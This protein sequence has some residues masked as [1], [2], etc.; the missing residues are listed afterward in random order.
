M[1]E[2]NHYTTYNNIVEKGYDSEFETSYDYNDEKQNFLY[3]HIHNDQFSK[4]FSYDQ[5]FQAD[6]SF[7]ASRTSQ[8][9]NFK[10]ISQKLKRLNEHSYDQQHFTRFTEEWQNEKYS[11][12]ILSTTLTSTASQEENSPDVDTLANI[13]YN[14]TNILHNIKS[15]LSPG[16][17]EVQKNSTDVFIDM[18]TLVILIVLLKR[19]LQFDIFGSEKDKEFLVKDT[20]S[21]RQSRYYRT[22]RETLKSECKVELNNSLELLN[23]PK[24]SQ[25]AVSSNNLSRKNDSSCDSL[26]QSSFFD[27]ESS[28]DITNS[29]EVSISDEISSL[30][31]SS[32]LLDD[33]Y[34]LS[35]SEESDIDNEKNV[36]C[37]SSDQKQLRSINDSDLLIPTKSEYYNSQ[38]YGNNLPQSEL[39]SLLENNKNLSP[40]NSEVLDVKDTS[41]DW[42]TEDYDESS[43]CSWF[44]EH[45]PKENRAFSL[46]R[47]SVQDDCKLRSLC[48]SGLTNKKIK[49]IKIVKSSVLQKYL[50]NDFN[51]DFLNFRSDA[52]SEIGDPVHAGEEEEEEEEEILGSD[53]DEQEDPK[54]YVKGVSFSRRSIPDFFT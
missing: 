19:W 54:D 50:C 2:D 41:S 18:L 40:A 43:E 10:F 49:R 9:S 22:K 51:L 47:K 12:K 3:P 7:L 36:I 32:S 29:I 21:H 44:N 5:V 30:S 26:S 39:D 16:F 24:L 27:D 23:T 46:P 53:D 45:Y 42:N 1:K 25:F 34:D 14:T 38:R 52:R 6:K 35:D 13:L 8:D 11:E 4:H 33:E 17:D 37:N 20:S 15:F 31:S 48:F 28:F